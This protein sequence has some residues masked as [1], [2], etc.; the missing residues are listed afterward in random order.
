MAGWIIL[1]CVAASTKVHGIGC[2]YTVNQKKIMIEA[3]KLTGIS[4]SMKVYSTPFSAQPTII[5]ACHGRSGGAL[6][7]LGVLYPLEKQKELKQ[8]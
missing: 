1:R 6:H 5:H 8:T 4:P 7:S 2:Y 3:D